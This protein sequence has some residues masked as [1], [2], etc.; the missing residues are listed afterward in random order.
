MLFNLS[1]T[2][3]ALEL[4]PNDKICLVA[5]SKCY[6]KLGDPQKALMDAEAALVEDKEFNKVRMLFIL[7]KYILSFSFKRNF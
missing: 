4:Q 2:F 5:R 7:I 3:Q 1:F 6:L